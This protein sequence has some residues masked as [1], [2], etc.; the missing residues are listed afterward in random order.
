MRSGSEVAVGFS[1]RFPVSIR[2]S[3][4]WQ[5]FEAPAKPCPTQFVRS[6]DS[7]RNSHEMQETRNTLKRCGRPGATTR[8]L[9][10]QRAAQVGR[11]GQWV[12]CIRFL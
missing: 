7:I 3:V 5:A 9:G 6:V 10:P 8:L 4:P 2:F 12:T 11:Q 1:S